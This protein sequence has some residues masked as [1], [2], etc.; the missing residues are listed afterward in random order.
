MLDRLPN[1]HRPKYKIA[2]YVVRILF[3][4]ILDFL[5]DA[6]KMLWREMRLPDG[7][8]VYTAP[9]GVRTK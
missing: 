2:K 5:I 1:C 9:F 4:P 6:Y 3:S 8:R 7:R